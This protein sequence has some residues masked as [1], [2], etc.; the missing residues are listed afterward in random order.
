LIGRREY[1][2][3]PHGDNGEQADEADKEEERH[4]PADRRLGD[5]RAAEVLGAGPLRRPPVHREEIRPE[6]S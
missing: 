6:P 1:T 4:R 5:V 2:Y 3:L